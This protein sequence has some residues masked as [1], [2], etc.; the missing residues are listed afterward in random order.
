MPTTV[1]LK[2]EGRPARERI[3]LAAHALFYCEGIRAT[4]VD[5]VIATAEVAKL[6]FYRHFPGKNDLVLAYLERQHENWIAWFTAALVRHRPRRGNPLAALVPTIAEWLAD[7][8]FRG[9]AFLNTVVELG[10]T[11]P[12]A[13]ALCRRNKQA[14]TAAI[15]DLLPPSR[16]RPRQARAIATAIDGV[17]MHAQF[18]PD[19]KA[20]LQAL[21]DLLRPLLVEAAD[22]GR[23]TVPTPSTGVIA[24]EATPVPRTRKLRAKK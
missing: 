4:G 2:L 8:R 9:C 18:E 3:L 12:A 10:T 6:T 20:P 15:A 1:P 23:K 24:T 14:M 11:L 7:P 21:R 22:G 5:R 17:V 19:A 13:T 16:Q